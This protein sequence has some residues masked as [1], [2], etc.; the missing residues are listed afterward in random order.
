MFYYNYTQNFSKFSCKPTHIA[1]PGI[2][3]A[4]QENLVCLGINKLRAL[5]RARSQSF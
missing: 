1:L 2:G 4:Y 5:F 3:A